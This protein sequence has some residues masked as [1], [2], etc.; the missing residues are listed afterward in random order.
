MVAVEITDQIRLILTVGSTRDRGEGM[1]ITRL[2]WLRTVEDV[3]RLCIALQELKKLAPVSLRYTVAVTAE[4]AAL[5]KELSN[6]DARL[7]PVRITLD[8]LSE[9]L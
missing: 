9:E 8:H 4:R 5:I 2:F 3:D 6:G 7:D 1:R